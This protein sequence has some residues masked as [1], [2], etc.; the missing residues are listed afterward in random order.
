MTGPVLE[1]NSAAAT[2]AHSA[3]PREAARTV[4]NIL[5]IEAGFVLSVLDDGKWRGWSEVSFL[6]LMSQ[7]FREPDF[8]IAGEPGRRFDAG[9]AVVQLNLEHD[10]LPAQ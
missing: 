8:G 4:I 7:L 3:S 2:F 6:E 10:G 1:N 5:Y 9:I